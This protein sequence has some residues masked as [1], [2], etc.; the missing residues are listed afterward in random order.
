MSF[1]VN[2]HYLG[3]CGRV[4]YQIDYTK[5]SSASFCYLF[6]TFVYFEAF[7]AISKTRSIEA[8]AAVDGS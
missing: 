1:H 5:Y 7:E 3:K 8:C 2:R 6:V 4:P